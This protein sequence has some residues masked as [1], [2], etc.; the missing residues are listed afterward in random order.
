M[1]CASQT[2]S[3]LSK[4]L[5]SSLELVDLRKFVS[6]WGTDSGLQGSKEDMLVGI[7]DSVLL[8]LNR[9]LQELRKM[10]VK[11]FET[12]EQANIDYDYSSQKHKEVFEFTERAFVS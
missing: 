1:F 2:L 12:S 9:A 8:D 10:L 11:V 5:I 4:G 6:T 3:C 7:A